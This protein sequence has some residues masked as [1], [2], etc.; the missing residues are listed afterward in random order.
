MRDSFGG[1][2]GGGGSDIYIM[3]LLQQLLLEYCCIS[4]CELNLNDEQASLL[5]LAQWFFASSWWGFPF[6]AI[7]KKSTFRNLLITPVWFFYLRNTL[8]HI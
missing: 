7:V 1:K 6:M 3:V 5:G 8:T 4:V 2:G